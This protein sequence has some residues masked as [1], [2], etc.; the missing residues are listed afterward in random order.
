MRRICCDASV[1]TDVGTPVEQWTQVDI[2]QATKWTQCSVS[3][4]EQSV[5]AVYKQYP[6]TVQVTPETSDAAIQ[7]LTVFTEPA[8]RFSSTMN[9][10][11]L[12]TELEVVGHYQA[13]EGSSILVSSEEIANSSAVKPLTEIVEK[14]H[15]LID[16]PSSG[17]EQEEQITPAERASFSCEKSRTLAAQTPVTSAT[18]STVIE[19]LPDQYVAGE[20]PAVV[21][22]QFSPTTVSGICQPAVLQPAFS[23]STGTK[24]IYSVEQRTFLASS[25]MVEQ[26]SKIRSL[27]YGGS[28]ITSI[29]NIT[30]RHLVHE[31]PLHPDTQALVNQNAA[32]TS[33]CPSFNAKPLFEA[34][35]TNPVERASK[36][37]SSHATVTE[38][39]SALK[40]LDAGEACSS[41]QPSDKLQR[42]VCIDKRSSKSSTAVEQETTTKKLTSSA[43][44]ASMSVST[45]LT[46]N[47][48][49]LSAIKVTE[50]ANVNYSSYIAA[51]L[52]ELV[53][54]NEQLVHF[55]AHDITSQLAN[56]KDAKSSAD[57]VVLAGD[58]DKFGC[59]KTKEKV[60]ECEKMT[61]S[62]CNQ[63]ITVESLSKR[64]CAKSNSAN[65]VSS[66]DV[67]TACVGSRA[68]VMMSPSG[69]GYRGESRAE[70]GY[71]NNKEQKAKVQTGMDGN[72]ARSGDGTVTRGRGRRSLYICRGPLMETVTTLEGGDNRLH[73]DLEPSSRKLPLMLL[74]TFCHY[75]RFPSLFWMHWFKKITT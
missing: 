68:V 55:A 43:V 25:M 70:S 23:M 19:Q 14:S 58:S 21:P 6:A 22:N 67:T 53:E 72:Q 50:S 18:I 69:S 75:H 31:T 17:E 64:T 37:V 5:Q 71:C 29:P 33:A 45:D 8:E 38:E 11:S 47:N 74:G 27:C 12:N 4:T 2:E 49:S 56:A 41:N 61:V 44:L 62:T 73:R 30:T 65:S 48:A 20:I 34:C 52:E 28:H 57:V 1:Q 36:I 26:S 10:D 32:Q 9:K 63:S 35:T 16:Y 54:S 60:L 15:T 39:S 3:H 66:V 42:S 51:R 13:E 40:P 7:T 46:Q 24:Y 59:H